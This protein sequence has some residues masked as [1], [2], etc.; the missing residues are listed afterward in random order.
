MAYIPEKHKKYN[1]LERWKGYEIFIENW[2]LKDNLCM[3]LGE[4][5]I[6]RAFES[7]EEALEYYESVKK[8][9]SNSNY[10][11]EVELLT[12]YIIDLEKKNHREVWSVLRYKGCEYEKYNKF[13]IG[14][15]YYMPC[16][17]DEDVFLGIL[18]D[19]GI[20]V[21]WIPTTCDIWEVVDDP[22]GLAA[23]IMDG[24]IKGVTEEDYWK[25]CDAYDIMVAMLKEMEKKYSIGR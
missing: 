18:D 13:E 16:M 17:E 12:E 4:G 21:D 3:L 2:D 8:R 15:Y 14:K 20:P 24:E 7:L 11:H 1:L 19:E 23:R 10:N 25:N 6:E 22:T 5:C 9:I